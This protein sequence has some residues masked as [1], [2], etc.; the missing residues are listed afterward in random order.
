[1]KI[2]A[3]VHY[4]IIIMTDLA[5]Q[6]R[7]IT[8]TCNDI[9]LRQNIS[10]A[11]VAQLLNKLKHAGLLSSVRGGASGGYRLTDIPSEITVKRIIDAADPTFCVCPSKEIKTEQSV[12]NTI[13][14]FWQQISIGINKM[15]ENT[16]LEDLVKKEKNFH[17]SCI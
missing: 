15:F 11:F 9:A 6:G 5:M 17:E 2:P 12:D 7:K 13:R 10:F 14:F 3:K 1:M 4:A 16:T 8:I